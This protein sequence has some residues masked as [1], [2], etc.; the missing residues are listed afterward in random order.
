MLVN[1]GTIDWWEDGSLTGK[2]AL[3]LVDLHARRYVFEHGEVDHELLHDSLALL[4]SRRG[5]LERLVLRQVLVHLV[6]HFEYLFAC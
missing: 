6:H 1:R 3:A 4:E 2:D 5:L